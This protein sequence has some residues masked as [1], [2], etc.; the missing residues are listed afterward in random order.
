MP[1]LSAPRSR[2]VR[3]AMERI[4]SWFRALCSGEYRMRIEYDCTLSMSRQ[5]SISRIA[6]PITTRSECPA[7][8]RVQIGP[9]QP[10]QPES[11]EYCARQECSLP[12]SR[13]LALKL[14]SILS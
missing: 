13:N 2:N 12:P 11:E 1:L 14:R 6:G 10:L 7:Q 3:A 9:K 8:E 4:L 5:K